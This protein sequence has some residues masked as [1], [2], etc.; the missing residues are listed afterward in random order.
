[1]L[2]S[3]TVVLARL[4]V[5]I[6]KVDHK[7]RKRS[8]YESASPFASD[9]RAGAMVSR[10]R[11]AAFAL[12][13]SAL[14]G[15]ACG[16][17]GPAVPDADLQTDAGAQDDVSD[18]HEAEAEHMSDGSMEASI[19]N[20]RPEVGGVQ[21]CLG[22][23]GEIPGANCYPPQPDGG[24]YGRCRLDG[25]DIEGKVIGAYC[26]N[27]DADSGMLGHTIPSQEPSG[28]GEC[29][30]VN[31]PSVLIC[32]RCGDDVCSGWENR[33]NCPVDCPLRRR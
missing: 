26:C 28:A 4:S 10:S 30:Q 7:G 32:S 12:L 23:P 13:L 5:T 17:D 14:S 3:S 16:T 20:N 8:G 6:W 18:T 2:S 31:P 33:C 19:C 22:C 15:S 25:E 9:E 27:H 21:T 11:W 1:M 29:V 24:I